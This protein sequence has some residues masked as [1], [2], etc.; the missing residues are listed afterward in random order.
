MSVEPRGV[1]A[2][3]WVGD[4]ASCDIVLPR[5]LDVIARKL[6]NRL[7][8]PLVLALAFAS[9]LTASFALLRGVCLVAGGVPDSTL[10]VVV[11]LA[12]LDPVVAAMRA[13]GWLDVEDE[14][15]AR[16]VDLEL[17]LGGAFGNFFAGDFEAVLSGTS[18]SSSLLS[19]VSRLRFT[20]FG[21]DDKTLFAATIAVTSP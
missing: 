7:L 18:S 8:V 5:K 3:D 4:P 12:L 1:V 13:D 6:A 21:L 20:D 19:A 9:A 10:T 2:L 11:V 14:V 16:G 15:V 17:V